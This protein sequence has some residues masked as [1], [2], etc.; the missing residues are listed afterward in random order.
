[1]ST[2]D[3]VSRWCRT[4]SSRGQSGMIIMHLGT[5]RKRK[6]MFTCWPQRI[7]AQWHIM[8]T[9]CIVSLNKICIIHIFTWSSTPSVA[10][11]KGRRSDILLFFFGH[12]WTQKQLS[13]ICLFVFSTLRS[14]FHSW[15]RIDSDAPIAPYSARTK[16][17]H[18]CS[19]HGHPISPCVCLC[20]PKSA[21]LPRGDIGGLVVGIILPV[22]Y[23]MRQPHATNWD[24][25]R[26]VRT[27]VRG[28]NITRA[29]EYLLSMCVCFGNSGCY[30]LLVI[31][32]NSELSRGC[33]KEGVIRELC[34]V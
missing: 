23:A 28:G 34:V 25:I 4:W 20:I 31:C 24:L 21:R 11:N 27:A 29:D 14:L 18:Y 26:N 10:D 5:S 12:A 7:G 9:M 32:G 6:R 15:C 8:R 1:M 17:R 16:F 13:F 2:C 3:A 19:G 33:T 30:F 22:A